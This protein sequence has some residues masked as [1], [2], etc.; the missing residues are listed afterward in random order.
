MSGASGD[1]C[2]VEVLASY[3]YAPNAEQHEVCQAWDG[4]ELMHYDRDTK[5]EGGYAPF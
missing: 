4:V 1:F 2:Q 5:W 3:L